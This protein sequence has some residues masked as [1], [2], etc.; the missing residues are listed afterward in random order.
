MAG[1]SNLKTDSKLPEDAPKLN[2]F[3]PQPTSILIPALNEEEPIIRVLAEIPEVLCHQIIVVDNG[4]VDRTAERAKNCGA[5]V[6]VEKRRGY[7]NACLAGIHHIRA[8]T[9]VVVF[10]DADHSDYPEEL[11]LLTRPIYEGRYDLVL[12]SRSL[13]R[14]NRS[15]LRFH[16]AWGNRICLMLIR[17]FYGFQFSDMGPFRAIR[18][19]SLTKL[20]LKDLTWGWNAEMQ[21][22]AVQ[23][24]LRILEV[25]V[26]YRERIGQSK[27][28]GTLRGSLAA[29]LRILHTILKHW[30]IHPHSEGA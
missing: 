20:G 26:R 18:Y 19:K 28:S 15:F 24:G 13:I 21:I 22:R 17:L 12:G 4:S 27:I 5:Q 23:E 2:W 6:V 11:P 10:L 14:E 16:Q 9:E 29:G 30:K 8:G 3:M 7:G 25:P 1:R